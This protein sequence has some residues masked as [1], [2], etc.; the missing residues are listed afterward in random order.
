MY[1]VCIIGAGSVGALKPKEIDSPRSESILTHAHAVWKLKKHGHIKEFY[2]ID[3]ETKKLLA[4]K[5]RWKC[6]TAYSLDNLYSKIKDIDIF[7]ISCDTIYHRNM[8]IEILEIFKP[9]MIIVEKPFCN[10]YRESLEVLQKYRERDIPIVINY[11]RRFCLK[12]QTLKEELE[13]NKYGRIRACNIIYVRGLERDGCHAIDLCNYFF[14]KYIKGKILGSPYNTYNDYNNE[15]LTCPIWM[16]YEKCRNVYLAPTDGRDYSI[17]EMDILTENGR[18]NI[19]D[20]SKQIRIFDKEPEKTFGKFYSINYQVNEVINN[21]IQNAL[22]FLHGNCIGYLQSKE[23]KNI[24][25]FCTSK[26]GLEVRRIIK[27]LLYGK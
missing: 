12:L 6:K 14:G 10:S 17:F 24:D 5:Q 1:N 4:S 26:D 11:P 8:A 7:V 22:Y 15:D 19:I 9:K 25:L 20:H 2:I 3:I 21:D 16:E 27:N 13:R 23:K 18:I